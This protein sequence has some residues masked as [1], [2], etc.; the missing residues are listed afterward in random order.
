[1]S[2]VVHNVRLNEAVEQGSQFIANFSTTINEQES[3]RETANAN[4]SQVRHS[5]DISYGI[6]SNSLWDEVKSF[7]MNRYGR[8]YGFLFKDWSDYAAT[9]SLVGTGDGVNRVF[10]LKKVYSDGVHTHSR[11]ITRPVSGTITIKVNG[12]TIAPGDYSIDLTTGVLTFDPGHAPANT[13]PVTATF[14]F[15]VP[16]RFGSDELPIELQWEQAGSLPS[17]TLVEVRE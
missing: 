9:D 4:W 12:V 15:Y 5:Y 14:E 17:I 7:F 13:H 10:Q 1:M 2:I 11:T 8:A 16:V 6:D 3:G